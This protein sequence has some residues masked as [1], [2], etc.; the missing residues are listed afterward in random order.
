MVHPDFLRPIGFL[1]KVKFSPSEGTSA[2]RASARSLHAASRILP[3]DLARSRPLCSRII[4]HD[5]PRCSAPSRA[6]CPHSRIHAARSSAPRTRLA[7][8]SP[9]PARLSRM[10]CCMLPR[11]RCIVAAPWPDH[12]CCSRIASSHFA[13]IRTL[14][15]HGRLGWGCCMVWMTEWITKSF[16][17]HEMASGWLRMDGNNFGNA[18]VSTLINFPPICMIFA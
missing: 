3:R 2:S 13:R 6:S 8:C 9:A 17:W 10:A 4:P 1:R 12:P 7:R 5:H 11:M 18:W 15:V 14:L 16:G